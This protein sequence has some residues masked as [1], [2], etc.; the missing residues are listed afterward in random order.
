MT[1]QLHTTL[2]HL[3]DRIADLTDQIQNV[4]EID[5][6]DTASIVIS[7]PANALEILKRYPEAKVMVL[8][9]EPS[10]AEGTRLLPHGIRG[11]ANTYIHLKHLE[12]ALESIESGNVWLYPEFMQQLI[13]QV[14]AASNNHDEVLGKLT[15]RERETAL[16]VKEGKSN[17]E[18]ASALDITERTVK[19][20]MSHIFEKLGVGDRFALA[21]LLK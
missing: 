12:Q 19:Q 18:I 16:L 9:N 10:F 14:T 7:D 13:G 1:T 15:E 5:T 11:Y 3:A 17:K 6:L 20:H 8:S 4:P 2:P 21:M